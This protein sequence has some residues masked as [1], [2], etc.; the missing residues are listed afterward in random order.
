MRS[1]FKTT[2]DDRNSISFWEVKSSYGMHKYMDIWHLNILCDFM[3]AVLEDD[4]KA[5]IN[6]VSKNAEFEH[7]VNK[8]GEYLGIWGF[9]MK[10]WV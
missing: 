1:E 8:K 9:G 3:M 2:Y 4:G 10:F 5:G 7:K 6:I